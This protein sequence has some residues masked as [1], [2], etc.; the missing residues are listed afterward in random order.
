MGFLFLSIASI[1]YSFQEPEKI[2]KEKVVLMMNVEGEF[3]QE[4]SVEI[5]EG[6][7]V[8]D[9]VKKVGVTK[10]ANLK[11][12]D[13][14]KKVHSEESLYLPKTRKHVISL[15]KGTAEDFMTLDGVGEKTAKKI[16]DYRKKKPFEC[17]EDIKNV[18]GIGEKR[19]LKY[20]DYLIL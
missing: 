6:W 7:T 14:G 3:K 18:S 8:K 12:L 10:K 11:A 17:L 19:Y 15:N 4:G 9:L 20:R 16:L 2:T 1:L 13:L 5:K